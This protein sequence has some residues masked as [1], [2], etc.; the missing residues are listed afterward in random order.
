MY[1][2][3][4]AVIARIAEEYPNLCSGGWKGCRGFNNGD[5]FTEYRKDMFTHQF[6]SEVLTSLAYLAGHVIKPKYGS[7][8]LKHKAEAFGKTVGL[9]PYVRNGALIVAAIIAGYELKFEMDSLNCRFKKRR[10]KT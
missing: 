1:D 5:K 7:Y 8:G 4:K 3:L 2:K 6:E 9:E 10:V